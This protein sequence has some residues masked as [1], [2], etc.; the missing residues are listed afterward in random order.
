MRE[1]LWLTVAMLLVGVGCPSEFGMEGRLDKA[2]E[3][4]TKEKVEDLKP[5]PAG[6]HWEQ[7]KSPCTGSSCQPGCEPDPDAGVSSSP[8]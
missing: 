3:H 2:A 8:P 6:T 5:C 7:A 1:H 4:D